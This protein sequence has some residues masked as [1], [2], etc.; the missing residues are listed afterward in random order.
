MKKIF[1]VASECLP[2]VKTGIAADMA[3]ALPRGLDPQ[4][5]DVRVALPFYSCIPAHF[6]KDFKYAAHFYLS[7][8]ESINNEYVGITTYER[9]GIKYYFIDNKRFF[10]GPR[11]YGEIRADLEKFCFFSKAALSLLPVINFRPDVIHCHDWQT[12]AIPVYLKTEFADGEFYRG[13]KSVLTVHNLANQG[14]A[15][16][17]TI[18]DLTGFSPELFVPD[19]LEFNGRASLLKG[20]IVYADAVTTDSRAH[21]DEIQT[22]EMGEGLDGLIRTRGDV[23]RGITVGLDHDLFD[24]STDENIFVKYNVNDFWARKWENK[25]LLQRQLGLEEDRSK[26]LVGV[27]SRLTNQKG[28]D[29]LEDALGEI[30]DGFT[31]LVVIGTGDR[32]HEDILK[33][34]EWNNRGSLSA[35][36]YYSREL[37]HRLYAGAD[38]LLVPSRSEPSG[39]TQLVAMRYGT[40]PIVRETG[41]LKDTVPPFNEYENE[42]LG[43]SFLNCSPHEL[44]DAVAYARRV[45]FDMPI[46]WQQMMLRDM[47]ADWSWKGCV[48][49]YGEIYDVLCEN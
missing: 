9:G 10:G 48:E 12:A 19:K 27:V 40:V 22:P 11:P 1:I 26:F 24:P 7:T 41:S 29:M 14:T 33:E 25:A 6:S 45:Y 37:S 39:L 42:G 43:F 49:E 21:A 46:I 2:F 18:R 4:K 35:N 15:D 16:I 8:G 38:A 3:A 31:Q 30:L 36:I 44:A 20:G 13:I 17:K 5:Y 23:L 47:T 34:A 32:R 28:I